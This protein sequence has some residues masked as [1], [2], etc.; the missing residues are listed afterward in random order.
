MADVDAVAAIKDKGA[1]ARFIRALRKDP[2]MLRQY[3]AMEPPEEEYAGPVGGPPQFLDE[4]APASRRRLPLV[5]A[6]KAA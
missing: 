3:L 1:M 6:D 2:D 5:D 4:P